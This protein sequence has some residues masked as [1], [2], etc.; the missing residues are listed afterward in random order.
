MALIDVA[1]WAPNSSEFV[2]AYKYPETNLSTYTQLLVHESQE[3]VLFSK[4]RLI[5][6]FG[7]GKHTLD[8]ENLPLLRNLFGIPF[9]GK[10][11][12]TA[13]VWII[14]KR[15]PAN[16]KWAVNHM[17][18]H[19]ADYNTQLPLMAEGQYSVRIEDAERFLINLVG[20]KTIFTESD[21]NEQVYGEYS[22][23]A[24]TAIMQFMLTNN[25]GYKKISAYL[26]QLSNVICS[27]V[28][29]F[30]AD[31]GISLVRCFVS[32]V[33]IDVTTDEGQRIKEAISNQAAM[34]I[35]GHTWQQ[36]Q[37]FGMAN[38]AVANIGSG[39]D[40][41][42]LIGGLLAMNM[43][44]GMQGSMGNGLLQQNY[45]Q[46]SFNSSSSNNSNGQV[47]HNNGFAGASGSNVRMIYCANC[48]RKHPSTE[49]FCAN[50]GHE[51]NPC[52][53][54]GNDNLSTAKRCISCGASLCKDS[55]AINHCPNCNSQ[56]APGLKFCPSCGTP[57]NVAQNRMCS[58]CGCEVSNSTKFCPNCGNKLD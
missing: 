25:V 39:G 6:K 31:Y 2:L 22:I 7:A 18:M 54:C 47:A 10:N 17:P 30:L 55:G 35:Q 41:G 37:M 51:Y 57:L 4:G 27:S 20:T 26:D 11:P 15:T 52:P 45:N 8:T 33:D 21:L 29:P 16:L 38:N 34:S 48:S 28:R 43:M 9:G 58:R 12:F 44:S 56:I 49:R 14:D 40:G 13:E 32:N 19:D 36:E 5:G 23:K 24:K 3:A 46:P 50:C 53:N 1:R 42:G